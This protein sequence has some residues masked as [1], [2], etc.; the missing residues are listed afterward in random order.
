M[1]GGAWIDRAMSPKLQLTSDNA[2]HVHQNDQYQ[3]TSTYITES[4]P[5]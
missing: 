3:T 1:I 4:H 5:V 2:D